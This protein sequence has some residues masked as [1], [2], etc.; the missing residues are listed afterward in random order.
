MGPQKLFNFLKQRLWS[1]WHDCSLHL[2]WLR[3]RFACPPSSNLFFWG[4][5]FLEKI[6]IKNFKIKTRIIKSLMKV[7]IPSGISSE[8]LGGAHLPRPS[9]TSPYRLREYVK[10]FLRNPFPPR[11]IYQTFWFQF[12]SESPKKI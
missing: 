6:N 8:G 7:E 3:S 5:S 10:Q 1:N 4:T 11:N 9:K 12:K 2:Q